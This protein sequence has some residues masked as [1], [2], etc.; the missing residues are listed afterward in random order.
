MTTE[1]PLDGRD[2]VS[3]V[4]GE[5]DELH[6]HGWGGFDFYCVAHGERSGCHDPETEGKCSPE[7]PGCPVPC[8]FTPCPWGED[9]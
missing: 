5:H 6:E 2:D 8:P 7:C 1:R 9:S 3:A 4:R